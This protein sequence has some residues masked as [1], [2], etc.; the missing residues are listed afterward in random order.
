[1]ASCTI[2]GNPKR[3]KVVGRKTIDS[4]PNEARWAVQEWNESNDGSI[5]AE[6]IRK[7]TAIGVSNGFFKDRFGTAC[8]VEEGKDS[9][10]R[11]VCT[12]IIPGERSDQSSYRSE[13]G[14]LFG[15]MVL[16][17]VIC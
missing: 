3:D 17:D 8:L 11:I 4:L 9:D 16:V 7:G 5:P 1:M 2:E 12:C 15:L 13:L 14:G 6:A 10:S